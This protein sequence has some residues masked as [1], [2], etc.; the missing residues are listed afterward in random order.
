MQ[1][2]TIFEPS[3]IPD[4]AYPPLSKGNLV[5]LSFRMEC[6]RLEATREQ[7]E[8]F[9]RLDDT[10]YRFSGRVR[11]RYN[12]PNPFIVIEALGFRFYT[13]EPRGLQL[14]R[15]NWVDGEGTLLLDYGDWAFHIL[16]GRSLLFN[17]RVINI[18]KVPIPERYVTR[19][20]GAISG[21][22]YVRPGA[23][24]AETRQPVET[25]DGQPVDW[26][27]YIVE[28]DDRSLTGMDIPPTF[29]RSE[30]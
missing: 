7:Q 22:T 28:L 18:W 17:F 1:L 13:L 12:K 4:K 14:K 3:L 23:Y 5:R 2:F 10:Q 25:M 29:G 30:M 20:V 16:G 27:F 19:G 21:P 6:T 9:T 26:L 24:E 8:R 15:G 11:L